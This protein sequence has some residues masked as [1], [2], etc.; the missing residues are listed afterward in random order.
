[1]RIQP[2]LFLLP[3]FLLCF[4]ITAV[5]QKLPQSNIYLFEFKALS[6]STYQYTKPA[7]LTSFNPLGYNNQP[8]F[9]SDHELYFTVQL[10]DDTTQTDIYGVDLKKKTLTQ[11]TSTAE[12]EYSAQ[13]IPRVVQ[14]LNGKK[15]IPQFSC[16]RVEADGVT[17][18]I[19]EFPLN[20]SNNGRPA[21][22]GINNIGYY[23]WVGQNGLAAF[24]V[25]DPHQMAIVN[26]ISGDSKNITSNIGR[27]L[28]RMPKGNMAFVHKLGKNWVIKHLDPLT[29]RSYL[30]TGTLPGSED[31]AVIPDGT[32]LMGNGSKLYKFKKGIDSGWMEVADFSYY[33]I[34]HITRLAV[35][36]NR[37]AIVDQ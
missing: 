25:G 2:A 1:M 14:D 12:S 8:Y 9:V 19:W 33:G 16:L 20:R 15:T 10:S 29:N 13:L 6:D 27:C 3:L 28:Q 35:W 26:R 18:R 5:A 36:G 21:I 4:G 7:Y 31:F 24:L 32:L 23:A 37:I 34:D 11:I 30:L 17:Q 22:P